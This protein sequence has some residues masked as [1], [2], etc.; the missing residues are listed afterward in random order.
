LNIY[1]CADIFRTETHEFLVDSTT[2][3][4]MV[5]PPAGGNEV[6]SLGTLS[7]TAADDA[8]L[9]LIR[10]QIVNKS[11]NTVWNGSNWIPFVDTDTFPVELTEIS[12]TATD[13]EYPDL[14]TAELTGASYTIRAQAIDLFGRES[15]SDVIILVSAHTDLVLKHCESAGVLEGEFL[16]GVMDVSVD[17]RGTEEFGAGISV[18]YSTSKSNPNLTG[19]A[20]GAEVFTS[21]NGRAR[22][23]FRAGNSSG[24]YTITA[25]CEE[26]TGIQAVECQVPVLE[27]GKD[28]DFGCQSL[29]GACVQIIDGEDRREVLKA[30]ILGFQDTTYNDPHT[31]TVKLQAK[32]KPDGGSFNWS[33]SRGADK[34]QYSADGDRFSFFGKQESNAQFDVRI[35]VEYSLPN[36]EDASDERFFTVQ[37]PTCVRILS[38]KEEEC[39]R[40]PQYAFGTHFQVTYVGLDQFGGRLETP[41]IARILA[42][43]TVIYDGASHVG[44]G[45]PTPD[46]TYYRHAH[47]MWGEYTDGV[48]SEGCRSKGQGNYPPNYWSS[49]DR[50][51]SI[52]AVPVMDERMTLK[53]NPSDLEIL[54]V[55]PFSYCD[56][57]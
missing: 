2:P 49:A 16:P 31:F 53:Q 5:L 18:R 23:P 40:L 56:E 52:S 45:L 22:I 54:P 43:E 47:L 8:G 24:T 4:I 37:R 3:A 14:A 25:Q 13:W 39:S 44:N 48:N 6:L 55:S 30:T 42:R 33:V 38:T 19:G 27:D 17:S 1:D 11:A 20:I 32:G 29:G 15:A 41:P 36:G 26:C 12:G 50:L 35:R 46:R 57:N 28:E 9:N 10:L 51:T 7:G 34:I 21:F